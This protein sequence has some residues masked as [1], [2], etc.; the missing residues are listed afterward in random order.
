MKKARFGFAIGALLVVMVAGCA[1]PAATPATMTTATPVP[2]ATVVPPTAQ[3]HR[4]G[5][6]ACIGV[7]GSQHGRFGPERGAMT[8]S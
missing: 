4:R 8:C 6:H 5:L 2:I 7:Y 1:A 3:V